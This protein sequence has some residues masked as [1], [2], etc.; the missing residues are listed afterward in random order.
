MR[1]LIL[2]GL[3]CTSLFFCTENK[4]EHSLLSSDEITI[5]EDTLLSTATWYI[6]SLNCSGSSRLVNLVDGEGKTWKKEVPIVTVPFKVGETKINSDTVTYIYSLREYMYPAG[7]YN[8]LFYEITFVD[9]NLYSAKD[10]GGFIADLRKISPDSNTLFQS[11]IISNEEYLPPFLL[12]EAKRRK[13][14]K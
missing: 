4:K 12:K 8:A 14:L 5:N 10:D 3:C 6:Y 11:E 13:V 7:D 2:T 1:I 9:G